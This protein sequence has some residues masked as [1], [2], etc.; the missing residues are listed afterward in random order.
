MYVTH[1]KVEATLVLQNIEE[2]ILKEDG[3]EVWFKLE[4]PMVAIC[5]SSVEISQVIF[6]YFYFYFI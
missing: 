4:P 1:D 5:C 2:K 3:G 6:F